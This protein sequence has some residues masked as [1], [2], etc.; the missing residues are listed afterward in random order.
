ME[1]KAL[2]RRR[3]TVARGRRSPAERTDA[4]TRLADL[5]VPAWRGLEVIAAH[6]AVGTE[7]PTRALLDGLRDAGVRVLL[8]VV[9]GDRLDWAPY[10]GWARLES[11]PFGLL[12]PAGGRLGPTVVARTDLVVVPALAVDDSGHRLGRGGGYYDRALDGLAV[13][14]VAVVFDDERVDEVPTE[15]HDVPVDGVL[16]PSGL[17]AVARA[18]ARPV[19][20]GR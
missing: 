13:P 7:P 19:P 10:D 14:G 4:G 1:A 9:D 20:M 8:P 5:A 15:Q 12:Q 18:G 3:V 16:S 6:A 17:T 11:G 2:A